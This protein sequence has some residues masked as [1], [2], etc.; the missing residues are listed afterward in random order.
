[1]DSEG[2]EKGLKNIAGCV[3]SGGTLYVSFPIGN[4]AVEFN[5]QRIIDPLWAEREL[6]NFTLEEFV[7]IPWKD[8]PIYGLSPRDVDA[9]VWGQA[10]LY[11]FKRVK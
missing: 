6:T 7:L 10:G 4:A 3:A 9:S 11:K 1:M 5:A 8:Q 2:H